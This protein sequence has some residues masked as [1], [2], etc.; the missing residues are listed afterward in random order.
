MP[1]MQ[2]LTSK[3]ALIDRFL[4]YIDEMRLNGKDETCIVIYF[5]TFED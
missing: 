1:G 5:N 3:N 2:Y 4:K